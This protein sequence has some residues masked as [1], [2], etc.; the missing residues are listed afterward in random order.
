MHKGLVDQSSNSNSQ[1]QGYGGPGERPR[2]AYSQGARCWVG[3]SNGLKVATEGTMRPRSRLPRST[4]RQQHIAG[5]PVWA[6]LWRSVLPGQIAPKVQVE[7][8]TL[9]SAPY[10]FANRAFLSASPKAKREAYGHLSGGWLIRTTLWEARDH[11]LTG[12]FPDTFYGIAC[13]TAMDPAPRKKKK[14]LLPHF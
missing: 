8:E 5:T 3:G 2:T 4:Q 7:Y 13:L 1:R 6:M 11:V 14:N 9:M 10:K 12:T